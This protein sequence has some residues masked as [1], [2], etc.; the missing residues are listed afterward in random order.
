MKHFNLEQMVKGWFVGG[1]EPTALSTDACEVAVKH[2]KAGDYESSHYHKIA[3]EIT[4]VVSGEVEMCGR[5]W[6]GGDIIV[7]SP[8]EV[9]DFRAL[10]DA[11]NV[12][13][14]S[15]GALNDK[16]VVKD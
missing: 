7:L 10:T 6:S 8:G 12:V 4:V 14:K 13:V 5:K 16:F 15:P 1:F 9:T 11:V 2:Y 3:T